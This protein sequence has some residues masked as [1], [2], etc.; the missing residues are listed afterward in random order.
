MKIIAFDPGRISSFAIFDTC[1]PDQIEMGEIDLVGSGRLLRPCPLM[2]RGLID[3]C[4]VAVVEEVGAMTKQ[5]VSSVFTFGLA[6]GSLLGGI[7]AAG[8][9]LEMV[10]PQEWKKVARL[11]GKEREE[12]KTLARVF[13]KEIWPQHASLLSVKKNHGMAEAALM[14]RWYFLIGPGRHVEDHGVEASAEAAS[15]INDVSV[16]S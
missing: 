13:A 6:L 12:A 15:H 9:C 14:T 11:N 4:D 3:Q 8:K 1:Q 7:G 16:S 2:V 5:G 10:R